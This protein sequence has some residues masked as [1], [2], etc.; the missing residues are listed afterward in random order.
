MFNNSNKKIKGQKLDKKTKCLICEEENENT[1]FLHKTRRQT[2]ILCNDCGTQYLTPEIKKIT[3]NLRNNIKNKINYIKC[4]GCVGGALR[5]MC[6]FSVDITKIKFPK[7]HNLITDIFRITYVLTNPN[8]TLCPNP[9]CGNIVEFLPFEFSGKTICSACSFVWCRNCNIKP[10]HEN[11]SCIKYQL[12]ENKSENIKYIK[13]L[14][15]DGSLKFCPLCNTPTIKK[16]GCNKIVCSNCD[17]KWCWLCSETKIDYSHFN[18][19]GKNKCANKLWE[20]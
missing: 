7:N 6:N 14:N 13:Q 12:S 5:N 11:I 10:Y 20:K 18:S 3:K 8:V 17:I 1:I 2:H 16:E 19:N 9:I 15:I 4:P